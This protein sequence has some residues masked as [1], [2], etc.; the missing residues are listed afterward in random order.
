MQRPVPQCAR[1]GRNGDFNPDHDATSVLAR[2]KTRQ[3]RRTESLLRALRSRCRTMGP[4][5]PPLQQHLTEWRAIRSAKGYP[6]QFSIWVLQVAH[7]QFFPSAVPS[8]DWLEDLLSYLRFDCQATLSHEAYIRKCRFKLSLQLDTKYAAARQ[9]FAAVR[10]AGHPPFTEV[11]TL[12]FSEVRLWEQQGPQQS[13]YDIMTSYS[14]P[15]SF[16]TPLPLW[17]RYRA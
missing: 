4:D 2:L 12:R 17:I 9:G 16:P 10:G 7:L 15:R 6:P 13:W 14:Q 1:P 3:V 5:A 8:L 11:P